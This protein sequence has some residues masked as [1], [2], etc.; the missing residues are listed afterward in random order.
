MI[1]VSVAEK[2][3][4]G[5]LKA[6]KKSELA[7]IRLDAGLYDCVGIKE[8]FSSRLNLIATC[9][10]GKFA[11]QDRQHRLSCAI[12]SGAAFVDIEFE[13]RA[14]YRKRLM[15]LAKEHSCRVILSFHDY[16]KTPSRKTLLKVINLSRERGADLVK[17][18]CLVNSDM[19][20]A[21]LLGLLDDSHKDLVVVGMGERG[22]IVRILSPLLGGAF[23][24]GS[25]KRGRETAPGQMSAEELKKFWK[26]LK[27]TGW[28][29]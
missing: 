5:C 3:V 20:A 18:A 21:R 13:E 24:F 15:S 27:T 2:T 23:T 6:V 7:E 4:E 25:S 29:W 11:D 10:R 16:S 1:C 19:D 8:I 28:K 17:I 22:R 12:E 9:R 26:I 14:A